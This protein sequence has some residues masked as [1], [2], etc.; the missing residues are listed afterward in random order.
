[1][2]LPRLR[3]NSPLFNQWAQSLCWWIE[4]ALNLTHDKQGPLRV[5]DREDG[6]TI[7]LSS[8]TYAEVQVQGGSPATNREMYAT[9]DGT[10]AV[11]PGGRTFPNLLDLVGGVSAGQVVRAYPLKDTSNEWYYEYPRIC[12]TVCIMVSDGSGDPVSGATVTLIPSSGSTVTATTDPGGNAC[13]DVPPGVYIA[14][15]PGAAD[16]D[17]QLASGCC[18]KYTVKTDGSTPTV[19]LCC[20][21]AATKLCVQC[22]A[23]CPRPADANP[24]S[25]V[26]VTVTDPNGDSLG[27]KTTDSSGEVCWDLTDHLVAGVYKIVGVWNGAQ[28]AS[29]TKNLTLCNGTVVVPLGGLAFIWKPLIQVIGCNGP[30]EGARVVC[31]PVSCTTGANGQCSLDFSSNIPPNPLA[32]TVTIPT[33][34]SRTQVLGL[35]GA[36]ICSSSFLFIDSCCVFVVDCAGP[37]FDVGLGEMVGTPGAEVTVTCNGDSFSGTTDD[38][39]RFC[40]IPA[41]DWLN[42]PGTVT[43]HKQWFRTTITEYGMMGCN[44]DGPMLPEPCYICCGCPNPWPSVISLTDINGGHTIVSQGGCGWSLCYTAPL[45]PPSACFAVTEQD[46]LYGF[47]IGP[48]G[49]KKLTVQWGT[50]PCPTEEGNQN[51]PWKC[52]TQLDFP[53]AL[54]GCEID[55]GADCDGPLAVFGEWPAVGTFLGTQNPVAGPVSVVDGC[56][57]GGGANGGASYY[58]YYAQGGINGLPETVLVTFGG[59]TLWGD[60][61]NQTIEVPYNP[62]TGN[63]EA[64]CIGTMTDGGNCDP[65]GQTEGV[66]TVSVTLLSPCNAESTGGLVAATV[67][68]TGGTA[69]SGCADGGC[70]YY[71]V[72]TSP[73]MSMG[74]VGTLL[75]FNGF[76]YVSGGSGTFGAGGSGFAE[77]WDEVSVPNIPSGWNRIGGSVLIATDSTPGGGLAPISSPN[78]LALSAGGVVTNV[79]MYETPDPFGGNYTLSAYFAQPSSTEDVAGLLFFRSVDDTQTAGTYYV[80]SMAFGSTSLNVTLGSVVGGSEGPLGGAGAPSSAGVWYLLWVQALEDQITVGV[81]RQ[82]DGAWLNGAT[83][84]WQAGFVPALQ[85]TDSSIPAAT[86]YVGIGLAT[87]A[88]DFGAVYSDNFSLAGVGPTVTLEVPCP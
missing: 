52:G 49:R 2:S 41:T 32:V 29:T 81:Q 38:T 33:G 30:I 58:Y 67:Q 85:V 76:T 56:G 9:A 24:I 22:T 34:P 88:G 59:I 54:D 55:F 68:W 39:G 70:E 53:V 36:D 57:G 47:S 75:A 87:T 23:L 42:K 83:A 37:H 60:A 43:T 4:R 20:Q 62:D 25:G 69:G 50:R 77:T 82:S 78:V 15:V 61:A 35:L 65:S 10:W 44:L 21:C 19:N 40:C 1:M 7:T 51:F 45:N 16:I 84:S 86:G 3:T 74:P 72:A 12:A 17:L 5:L 28:T 80:L 71:G 48:D 63:Y 13:V 27:T 31:G 46:V 64:E 11:M 73:S 8:E 14:Q 79:L 26:A 6:K 18:C 66:L